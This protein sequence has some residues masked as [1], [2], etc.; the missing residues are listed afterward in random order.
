MTE[1]E[2]NQLTNEELDN[3]VTAYSIRAAQLYQVQRMLRAQLGEDN[4]AA[5]IVWK[6]YLALNEERHPYS[7]VSG[8]RMMR[9]QMQYMTT[10]EWSAIV[11]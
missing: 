1:N 6:Q 9:E 8:Q 5:S 7:V 11:D 2:I 10:E 3:L 4:E